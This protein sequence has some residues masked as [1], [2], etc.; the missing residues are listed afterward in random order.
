MNPIMAGS[1]YRSDKFYENHQLHHNISINVIFMMVLVARFATVLKHYCRRA[2]MVSSLYV[3]LSVT[4]LSQERLDMQSPN[5]RK[6]SSQTFR[7]RKNS[8]ENCLKGGEEIAKTYRSLNDLVRPSGNLIIASRE[9]R[10]C[11]EVI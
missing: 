2:I 10:K 1:D 8:A 9:H 5:E 3:C 6:T 7:L 4:I 11:L